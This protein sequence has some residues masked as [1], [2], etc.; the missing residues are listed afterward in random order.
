MKTKL[1]ILTICLGLVSLGTSAKI[2]DSKVLT[3]KSL[4]EF[5]Q[6]S[7]TVSNAPMVVNNEVVKTFD[8][9]YENIKNPVHIG[10]VRDK[11]KVTY[12][13]RSNEFEVLYSC[14]KGVFG[15]KSMENKFR[16]LPKDEMAKKLDE[17]S[18]YSQ[19]VICTNEKSED[20]LLGLIACYFPALVNEKYQASF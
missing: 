3:G 16:T 20:E 8:L 4:T 13:V 18:F 14:K 19:R 2:K 5:G 12:I 17:V 6:Y 15:V 7:I 10:V 1:L 9:T 11:N